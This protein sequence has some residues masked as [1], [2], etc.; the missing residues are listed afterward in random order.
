MVGVHETGSDVF[1]R[2]GCSRIDR[3]EVHQAV[4]ADVARDHRA[5]EKVHVIKLVNNACGILQVL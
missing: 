5:L 2:A 1:C 3:V 4:V